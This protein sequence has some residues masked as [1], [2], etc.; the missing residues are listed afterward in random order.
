MKK[1]LKIKQTGTSTVVA[2]ILGLFCIALPTQADWQSDL[3]GQFDIVE[4][5]D[6]LQDWRGQDNQ[7][8]ADYNKAH[9]PTRLDGSAS[10]WDFYDEW[11]DGVDSDVDW[12][13]NYPGNVWHTPTG[14][15]LQI[16]LAP[17]S[18]AAASD[19]SPRGPSKFGMYLGSDTANVANGYSTSGLAN[20]GYNDVHYFYMIKM[21]TKTFPTTSG[22]IWPTDDYAY[23]AYHKFATMGTAF[24][25]AHHINGAIDTEGTG[26]RW[27]YGC[28]DFL[29]NWTMCGSRCDTAYS[30][31]LNQVGTAVTFDVNAAY[32]STQLVRQENLK[33]RFDNFMI[34]EIIRDG[35]WFG[36]EVHL[37][38]GDD[39]NT[40]TATQKGD[41]QVEVWVYNESGQAYLIYENSEM[42]FRQ[43]GTDFAFNKF[44]FGGN[45]SYGDKVD[46][47]NLKVSYFVDDFIMDNQRIGPNYF[48]MLN[49]QSTIRADVDQSSS[50]NSTDALL[51]LRNSL[52]LDMSSTNW[53][54]SATTGDVNCDGNTNS[55]DAF[56]TLR[57]SLG[58]NMGGTD[59]CIN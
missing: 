28:S 23:W 4:T 55:T 2:V 25:D 49:S 30:S 57:S 54:V 29:L 10:M 39:Q 33:Q 9:M 20:S 46:D 41:G 43:S 48:S 26:C 5:F 45:M 52:G 58:L 35:E 37:S 15:S 50:I 14:K 6:N 42:V 36:L 51:T 21:N 40:N 3:E 56:L 47:Q 44:F 59:W 11:F 8:G 31:A 22:N 18:G 24:T 17:T 32:A 53:Q 16:H 38:R 12:I 1:L 7:K 34:N 19:P 13:K 27:E